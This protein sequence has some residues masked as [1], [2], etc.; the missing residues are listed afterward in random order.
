MES[1]TLNLQ[2]KGLV[3]LK[4]G[5]FVNKIRITVLLGGTNNG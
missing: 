1:E 4:P 2:K 3:I 5:L